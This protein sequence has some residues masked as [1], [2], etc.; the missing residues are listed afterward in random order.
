M[1]LSRVS[2]LDA[3]VDALQL[4]ALIL[5]SLRAVFA[6]AL[7]CAY[8]PKLQEE[9]VKD[10]PSEEATA[11]LDE[12]INGQIASE[13]AETADGDNAGEQGKTD[14]DKKDK[15]DEEDEDEDEEEDSKKARS[16]DFAAMYTRLRRL[17]PYLVPLKSLAVQSIVAV[18]VVLT[19]LNSAMSVLMP[20][21][22]GI[23]GTPFRV[24]QRASAA[25]RPTVTTRSR[26]ARSRR[27]AVERD[28]HLVRSA[29]RVRIQRRHLK[30]VSLSLSA[31]RSVRGK[32]W[33]MLDFLT[34]PFGLCSGFPLTSGPPARWTSC[35]VSSPTCVCG[36]VN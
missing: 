15:D 36:Q 7:G 23:I 20:R 4:L 32:R 28:F 31:D 33:L 34:Q 30:Y 26:Q 24:Y 11:L 6:I 14:S 22:T 12:D 25:L 21:Q 8:L 10:E 2:S 16:Y 17:L 35:L 29:P 5:S 3:R 18:C 19:L 9:I 13:A 27:I 1:K